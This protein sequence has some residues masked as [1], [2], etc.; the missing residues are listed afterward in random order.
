MAGDFHLHD[1]TKEMMLDEQRAV[2][3]ADFDLWELALEDY[4]AW[5]VRLN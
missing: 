5:L 1:A 2:G 3:R 4:V